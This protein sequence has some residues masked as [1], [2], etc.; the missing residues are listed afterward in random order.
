MADIEERFTSLRQ[1][2]DRLKAA[3]RATSDD[4]ERY[5]IHTQL[6]DCIRESL[7]LIEQRFS[8]SSADRAEAPGYARH[9]GEPIKE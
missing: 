1:E 7:H 3:L 4:A 6:N 2:I 9:A 5:T 8:R